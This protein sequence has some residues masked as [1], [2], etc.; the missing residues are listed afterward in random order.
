MECV[1]LYFFRLRFRLQF[2]YFLQFIYQFLNSSIILMEVLPRFQQLCV[3]RGAGRSMENRRAR[4]RTPA[5]YYG[6]AQALALGLGEDQV[7][8]KLWIWLSPILRLR[9]SPSL[10][11]NQ[12]FGHKR[13]VS[14]ESPYP[15]AWFL[16]VPNRRVFFYYAAIYCQQRAYP[17]QPTLL[18]T[19]YM[20]YNPPYF[21]HYTYAITHSA[22]YQIVDSLYV[23]HARCKASRKAYIN[24]IGINTKTRLY[25]CYYCQKNFFLEN[26]LKF[27]F[28][29]FFGA[30]SL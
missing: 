29:A 21:I 10:Y 13:T 11:R 22:L 15:F 16:L 7:M 18:Y 9:L 8:L 24:Y 5:A 19:Q 1:L 2:M 26:W 14:A 4:G 28:F 6:R 23:L 30:F 17:L 3:R 25:Y 20:C 12:V 27:F